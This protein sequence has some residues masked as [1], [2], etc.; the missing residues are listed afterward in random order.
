MSFG[1][2]PDLWRQS[3]LLFRSIEAATVEIDL[4]DVN[5]VDSAGLALVVAW[6]RLSH[7]NAEA[8]RFTHI[9]TKLLALAK[10]NNLGDLLEPD[11]H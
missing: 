7:R 10:A 3:Q 6:T 4:R 5:H 2:V 9:P 11:L 8:L 1:S